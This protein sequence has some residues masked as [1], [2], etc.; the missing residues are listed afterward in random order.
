MVD[1]M[2]RNQGSGGEQHKNTSCNATTTTRRLENFVFRSRL[3][4]LV[5][6]GQGRPSNYCSV[7]SRGVI[8]F[9]PGAELRS[10]SSNV[11]FGMMGRGSGSSLY[12][13]S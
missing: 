6:K 12:S 9:F 13:G 10:N 5:K 11:M 3:S 8:A 7:H 4:L 2:C 1:A